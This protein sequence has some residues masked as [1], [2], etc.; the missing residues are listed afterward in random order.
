[1]HAFLISG[2][3]I[4][5]ADLLD[6]SAGI[7]LA[8]FLSRLTWLIPYGAYAGH[9]SIKKFVVLDYLRHTISHLRYFASAL[10]PTRYAAS[11]FFGDSA[12]IGKRAC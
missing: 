8:I 6:K 5:P 7:I 1:M 9:N 2:D 4:R 3:G 11:S 10:R 12:L